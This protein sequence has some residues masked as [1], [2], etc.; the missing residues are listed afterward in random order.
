MASLT[1]SP[2]YPCSNYS[3][4]E[5]VHLTLASLLARQ[6]LRVSRADYGKKWQTQRLGDVSSK[7]LQESRVS[8]GFPILWLLKCVLLQQGRGWIHCVQPTVILRN[9]QMYSR[10]NDNIKDKQT[11]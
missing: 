6:N 8:G 3:Q 5:F 10:S 11:K 2:G 9:G 1:P 4:K 7:V